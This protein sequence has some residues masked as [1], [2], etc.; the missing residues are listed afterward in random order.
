[1]KRETGKT[2]NTFSVYGAGRPKQP[3]ST[4]RKKTAKKSKK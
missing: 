4:K 1:M 3:G 2:E